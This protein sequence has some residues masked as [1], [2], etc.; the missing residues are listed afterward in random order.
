MLDQELRSIPDPGKEPSFERQI[1]LQLK[2]NDI[3]RASNHVF[4]I[5]EIMMRY[6]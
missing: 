5:I 3:R 1:Q 2:Y 6:R 4:D